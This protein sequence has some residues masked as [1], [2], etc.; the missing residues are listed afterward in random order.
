MAELSAQII[1]EDSNPTRRGGLFQS[2]I[3]GSLA[4]IY[5]GAGKSTHTCSSRGI[6]LIATKSVGVGT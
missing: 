3:K 2:T 6:M 4:L 1:D 5:D